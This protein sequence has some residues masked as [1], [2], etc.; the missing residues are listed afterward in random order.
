M[1]RKIIL[2][3]IGVLLVLGS[4]MIAKKLI[5]NKQKP[6]QKFEKIIKTVFTEQVVNKDVP[7]SITTSGRVV[8]K[9]KLQLFTEVQGVLEYSSRDFKAGTY[10][11]KGSVIL[12]INSDELRA[13]LKS[14]KSNL[15]TAL[16]KLLPDL[17]LD[18]AE[19][20]PK[21][22]QYI[23]SFDIDKPLVKLPETHSDKEKFFIS[24]RGIYTSFYNIKNVEVKL[25]K[26]VIRAPFS[27]V[28]S[29]AMVNI[30]TLVRPGQKVGELID[31]SV[32]ELEVA[33]NIAFVDMLKKG[34]TVMLQNIEHTKSYQGKVVRINGKV[35]AASQTIKVFIEVKG[36]DIK[37]GLYL[38]A[39]LEG[40][41]EKDVYEIDRKLLIDRK[42][43]TVK[44]D[45]ILTEVKV[46]PVH[47]N[48]KTV[49]VRGLQDGTK[50]LTKMVPGAYDGML[51]NVFE[52][53]NN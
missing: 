52:E 13:N 33:V 25:A 37:E 51:V 28:L 10:Y 11:P 23:A 50:V 34:N 44:A 53:K 17:R 49:L 29:E 41:L 15:F 7:V 20:F 38:E 43:Y 42:V 27:G 32:Y 47:F 3:L 26:Y 36:K 18:Y 8:A 31:P 14:M 46:E 4:V 19:E 5:A 6:R 21:W 24:G 30:G 22:E 1:K 9:N 40:Q 16:S 39:K 2:A 35:D 48:E 12:R 45:S